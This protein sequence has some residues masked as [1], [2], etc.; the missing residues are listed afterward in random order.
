MAKKTD[1]PTYTHDK[2]VNYDYD[3]FAVSIWIGK[4][5]NSFPLIIRKRSK[6][7]KTPRTINP[8]DLIWS[9]EGEQYV[10][11]RLRRVREY[12][13]NYGDI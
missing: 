11:E 5:E 6:D 10:K 8:M 1:D 3:N 9:E 7:E 12:L 13:E 2:S 4:D